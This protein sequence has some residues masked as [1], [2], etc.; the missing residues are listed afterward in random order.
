MLHTDLGLMQ[1]S[2]NFTEDV[3]GWRNIISAAIPVS[4]LLGVGMVG[5]TELYACG[6]GCVGGESE[7]RHQLFHMCMH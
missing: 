6:N 4:L 5:G 2:F 7:A 3:G 1:V